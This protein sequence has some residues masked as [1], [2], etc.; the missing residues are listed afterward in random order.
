MSEIPVIHKAG[1]FRL[2]KSESKKTRFL[3]EYRSVPSNALK[4]V[5][6]YL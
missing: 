3:K 2:R 4:V 1:E 6:N 5:E